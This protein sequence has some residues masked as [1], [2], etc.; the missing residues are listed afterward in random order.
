MEWREPS[1]KVYVIYGQNYIQR[2]NYFIFIK[3]Q[4]HPFLMSCHSL[5]VPLKKEQKIK[6]LKKSQGNKIMKLKVKIDKKKIH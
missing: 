4:K 6:K 3:K 5:S 1:L 2:P